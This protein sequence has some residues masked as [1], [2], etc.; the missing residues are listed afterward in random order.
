M[1]EDQLFQLPFNAMGTPEGRKL[2]VGMMTGSWN[3]DSKADNKS[4]QKSHRRCPEVSGCDWVPKWACPGPNGAR[5]IRRGGAE[6]S[7][8]G[9]GRGA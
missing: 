3:S 7:R 5:R 8:T 1:V 4:V 6:T 9:S 2:T